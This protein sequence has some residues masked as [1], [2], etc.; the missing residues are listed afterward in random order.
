M[1]C[2]CGKPLHYNHPMTQE[3]MEKLVAE[4]G[5]FVTI[6]FEDKKYK[7]QRHYVAIHG[8]AAADLEKLADKG[9]VE[10]A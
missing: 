2:A 10:R 3:L 7:V 9:L 4:V 6:V 8:I 5:E 1:N